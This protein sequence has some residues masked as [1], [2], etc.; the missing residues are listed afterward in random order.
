MEHIDLRELYREDCYKQLLQAYLELYFDTHDGKKVIELYDCDGC[1][2]LDP[3]FN[4]VYRQFIY[5]VINMFNYEVVD[6]FVKEKHEEFERKRIER[7]CEDEEGENN[8]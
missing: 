2:L 5:K 8:D 3:T 6:K 4:V 1:G 7:N